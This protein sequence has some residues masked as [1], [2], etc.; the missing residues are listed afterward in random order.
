MLVLAEKG[1]QKAI[2]Q[3]VYICVMEADKKLFLGAVL[4]ARSG[5]YSARSRARKIA[6]IVAMGVAIETSRRRSRHHVFTMLD[7][8]LK[9]NH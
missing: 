8:N 4:G 5:I 6:I 1:W 9:Q 2:V 3:P 7:G